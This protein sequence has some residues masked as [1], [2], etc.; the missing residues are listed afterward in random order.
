MSIL[1]FF[2]QDDVPTKKLFSQNV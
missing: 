1:P 2:R